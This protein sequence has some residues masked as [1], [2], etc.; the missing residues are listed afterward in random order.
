MSWSCR[1][2]ADANMDVVAELNALRRKSRE[3]EQEN[4]KLKDEIQ[5]TLF[6]NNLYVIYCVQSVQLHARVER[7]SHLPHCSVMC[8]SVWFPVSYRWSRDEEKVSF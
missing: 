1:A 3:T 4:L 7:V 2:R 5:V 8:L 6:L